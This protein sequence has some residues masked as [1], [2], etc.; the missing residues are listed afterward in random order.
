MMP[1]VDSGLEPESGAMPRREPRPGQVFEK[2][3]RGQP[4]TATGEQANRDSWMRGPNLRRNSAR[5]ANATV[6]VGAGPHVG[7]V[8]MVPVGLVAEAA[9]E[10][11]RE[12]G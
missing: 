7:S 9:A 3:G 6:N 4:A 12:H 11:L 1:D 2:V 5:Q 8:P 10:P